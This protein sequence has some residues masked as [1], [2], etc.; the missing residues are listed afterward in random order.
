[1]GSEILN[2]KKIKGFKPRDSRYQISDAITKGLVI[3][4]EPSGVK[5]FYYRY[6][7]QKM[8]K[9]IK[10]GEY[11]I[12]SLSNARERSFEYQTLI[13]KD[14]DPRAEENQADEDSDDRLKFAT[15]CERYIKMR[16]PQLR[17]NTATE[18]LRIIKKELEPKL[19]HK[20]VEEI[21]KTDVAKLINAI[22]NDRGKLTM[23]NRVRQRLHSIFEFGIGYLGLE[24]NPVS[25]LKNYE[26]GEVKRDRFYTNE[27]IKRLWAAFDQQPVQVGAYFKFLLLL[28]QRKTETQ[29]AKWEH[30]QNGI[31][32]IPAENTKSKRAH[33]VPLPAM[34]LKL[35]EECRK[36]AGKN[37]YI[38]SSLRDYKIHFSNVKRYVGYIKKETGI[39][40]FRVHDLRRTLITNLS[41][42]KI[43]RVVS[44]KLINH[45]QRAGDNEVTA[46][47]D[48]Y[49]YLPEIKNAL[50][51]W[52]AE[53]QRIIESE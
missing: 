51:K 19:G 18:H 2:D 24:I 10:I 13:T 40:D 45:K 17:P 34:A 41:M 43:D 33:K 3:R 50:E 36:E 29:K 25:K 37:P 15:L 11:P 6:T 23:A 27:E 32:N 8:K 1:M 28:G 30:I 22:A 52:E 42:L 7:F 35:L 53:L 9:T 46:I 16:L 4:V 39:E 26:D 12:V 5:V 38:F 14:I 47:Y 20:Y 21:K 49:D 31:W 44:G 48:R